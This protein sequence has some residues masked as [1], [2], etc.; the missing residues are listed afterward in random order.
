MS[1]INEVLRDLDARHAA[2]SE[3]SG[4]ARNV[5]ALPG[6]RPSIWSRLTWPLLAACSGGAVVWL[7][8]GPSPTPLPAPAAPAPIAAPAPAAEAAVEPA[9]TAAAE[10]TPAA[11]ADPV[12]LK[13]EVAITAAPEPKPKPA[14]PQS[15]PA[16]PVP[17]APRVAAPPPPPAPPKVAA[18][19][20]PL[21]SK[22]LQA[23]GNA[24]NAPAQIN[25]QATGGGSLNEQAEAEY[26]RG[27]N[28]A[29]RGDGAEASDAYRAAI[30]L[31]NN[32]VLARQALLSLLVEQ[33]QWAA[34]EVL[35]LDGLGIMPNRHDWALLAARVQFE[36][37]EV[38]Q[39]LDTLSLHAAS[40]RGNADYQV[41]HALLL[42]RANRHAEAVTC[43]QTA[44]A[45]NPAEGRWW[46]GLA[47]ALEAD[48]REPEARQAY[49]KA[50]ASGN[51][52]PDLLQAVERRLR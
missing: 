24:S 18:A 48:H 37:G 40:A 27:L 16:E 45:I 11:P 29:R 46:Y 4:L 49:E 14:V 42:Q 31:Q 28:A 2:D 38:G 12:P 19:D 51:L 32:H 17:A 20:K 3:R 34:V 52:P 47:R 1:L 26:R 44:L 8:I 35:A 41:F 13:L 7:L 43:Y 6:A 30:K 23:T 22:P 36:R 33:R 15:R 10:T 50:R 21:S 9:P 39:A 25:K 5:K